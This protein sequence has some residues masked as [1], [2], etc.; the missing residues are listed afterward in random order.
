M[1]PHL[2]VITLAVGDLDRSLAFYRALRVSSPRPLSLSGAARVSWG[3]PSV[4]AALRHAADQAPPA[5]RVRLVRVLSHP[6]LYLT[7]A[8]SGRMRLP[9]SAGFR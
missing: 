1:E 6:R 9:H 2:D 5:T 8:A 7:R 3:S 4:A